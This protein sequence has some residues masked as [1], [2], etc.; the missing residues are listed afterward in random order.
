MANVNCECICDEAHK[1]DEAHFWLV[2]VF[3]E[4]IAIPNADIIDG[5]PETECR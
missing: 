2:L 5:V 3:G 4:L 1:S